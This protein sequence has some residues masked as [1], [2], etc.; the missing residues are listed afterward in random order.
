MDAAVVD[1]VSHKLVHLL[2]FHHLHVFLP[3][4]FTGTFCQ[5]H[6]GGACVGPVRYHHACAVLDYDA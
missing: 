2:V 5:H 6:G 4:L 3:F 1:V